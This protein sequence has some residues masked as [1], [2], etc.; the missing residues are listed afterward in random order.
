M[1]SPQQKKHTTLS[2]KKNKKKKFLARLQFFY[3]FQQII[4]KLWGNLEK[5]LTTQQFWKIVCKGEMLRKT[6]LQTHFS[7]FFCSFSPE[8]DTQDN[9]AGFLEAIFVV[10]FGRTIGSLRQSI[11][12]KHRFVDTK[13]VSDDHNLP[14][15]QYPT[16]IRWRAFLQTWHC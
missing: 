14:V 6:K 9:N 13:A 5:I 10:R 11:W 16:W 4:F 2:G 8:S 12:E 15:Q 3:F 1:N 7:L